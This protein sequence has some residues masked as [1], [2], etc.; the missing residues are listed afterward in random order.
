MDD[1]LK[2]FF[3]LVYA[4][5]H[6][7]KENNYCKYDDHSLQ[8]FTS[9]LYLAA[10][11]ASFFAATLCNKYGRRFTMK[12]ASIFFLVG[13]VLTVVAHQLWILI[14]GRILL[15]FGIGCGNQVYIYIELASVRSPHSYYSSE[16]KW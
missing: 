9:S 1:F 12:I 4:R 10:L 5:K 2:E 8:L 13:V 16:S 6:H 3:P 14:I 15:G 11:I 7:V